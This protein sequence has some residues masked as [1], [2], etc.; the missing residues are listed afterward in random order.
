M[1]W[2]CQGH[3]PQGERPPFL[4]SVKHTVLSQGVGKEYGGPLPLSWAHL[5]ATPASQKSSKSTFLM[6]IQ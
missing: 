1:S 2:V 5:I 6:D 4:F 3:Q